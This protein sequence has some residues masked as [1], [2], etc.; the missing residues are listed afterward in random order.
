MFVDNL[1]K[2]VSRQLFS[3]YS[4]V[5]RVFI[6]LKNNRP[7]YKE[8]TFAF[9]LFESQAY[10]VNAISKINSSKIDGRVVRVS[11][12]RY[13]FG[14]YGRKNFKH[15][16]PDIVENPMEN[17]PASAG[18]HSE[19]LGLDVNNQ[20]AMNT[21]GLLVKLV[22]LGNGCKSVLFEVVAPLI[23]EDGLPHLLL[24]VKLSSVPLYYWQVNFFRSLGER[25]G[26]LVRLSEN[27]SSKAKFGVA[28]I[29]VRVV[30]PLEIPDCI[31]ISGN[32]KEYLI[33]VSLGSATKP[34]VS[35]APSS[36]WERFADVWVVAN[37]DHNDS[38]GGWCY[39]D[40]SSD[41]SNDLGNKCQ[42]EDL[43]CQAGNPNENFGVPK[44]DG[45]AA[46]A[47]PPDNVD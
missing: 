35:P 4:K 34:M 40:S 46:P 13:V 3:H 12:A 33:K 26:K 5:T 43:A 8:A 37:D 9:V 17:P 23:M 41:E 21:K 14:Q 42:V 10:L 15:I 29:F 20:R 36:E 25:W 39:G 19:N 6:S 16:V 38:V 22:C 31:K 2:R 1:S 7:R 44:V 32:G 28:K 24:E 11:K 30:S 45:S 27:T 47:A 18:H